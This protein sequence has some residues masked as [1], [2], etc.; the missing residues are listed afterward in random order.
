MEVM[1]LLLFDLRAS[2][3]LIPSQVYFHIS[4][5][6]VKEFNIVLLFTYTH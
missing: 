2:M 4:Q 5:V 3:L 6:R 1:D